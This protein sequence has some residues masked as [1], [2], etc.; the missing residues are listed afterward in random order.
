MGYYQ[1]YRPEEIKKELLQK[2]KITLENNNFDILSG[3][4]GFSNVDLNNIQTNI[5]KNLQMQWE[6][7][8]QPL[9]NNNINNSQGHHLV[10][11]S[12]NTDLA[13][14]PE[15]QK[16]L[17]EEANVN[18]L[19]QM[20][21][22]G[23][24]QQNVEQVP[25]RQFVDSLS[26][27]KQHEQSIGGDIIP[28]NQN[29]QRPTYTFPKHYTGS[30]HY[31]LTYQHPDRNGPSK[32]P[33]STSF[34]NTEINNQHSGQFG[35]GM[36]YSSTLNKVLE[37]EQAK[38]TAGFENNTPPSVVQNQ[39]QGIAQ[40]ELGN[41][42][43]SGGLGRVP[44]QKST[45]QWYGL[46]S[47]GQL[48]T[49]QQTLTDAQIT[50]DQLIEKLRQKQS[51]QIKPQVQ[52]IEQEEQQGQTHLSGNVGPAQ[53]IGYGLSQETG[54][55]NQGTGYS[56]IGISYG[57]ERT[58]YGSP[59]Y[60]RRPGYNSFDSSSVT[61]NGANHNYGRL[62]Y[63]KQEEVQQNFETTGKLGTVETGQASV[64]IQ[65]NPHTP[66]NSYSGVKGYRRPVL[67]AQDVSLSE[68]PGLILVP[69]PSTST[70]QPELQEETTIPTPDQQDL[71]WWKRFGNK[72]AQGAT[73]LK[74]KIVG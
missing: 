44:L 70:F 69:S 21:S 6:R 3:N 16:T 72:I 62:N 50:G 26:Y 47:Q 5:A 57:N 48:L 18:S 2:V 7:N 53:N 38:S 59:T 15:S 25:Q 41:N 74:K 20:S 37:E 54:Y 36:Y 60:N 64:V 29:N 56:S 46:S 30:R 52:V 58:S 63:G 71:P 68:T 10:G 55:V 32:L 27:Q 17:T 23:V 9:I 42:L 33:D 39:P 73:D 49:G 22:E 65:S 24:P 66:T 31:G 35:T 4:L 67:P 13:E 61:T 1:N 40:Q 12:S 34:I 43:Q 8:T 51:G 28:N 14:H 45:G 11:T 19:N